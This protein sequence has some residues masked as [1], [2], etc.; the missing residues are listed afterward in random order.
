MAKSPKAKGVPS[1]P[2]KQHKRMAMGLPIG[3]SKES[4]KKTPA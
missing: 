1:G 2:I 4:S 3:A